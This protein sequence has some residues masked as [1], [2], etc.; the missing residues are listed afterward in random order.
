MPRFYALAHLFVT[1]S[2][3][4]V[5]PMTLI[6]A[7]TSGLPIVARF[8]PAYVGLARDGYSGYLVPSDRA[9]AARAMELLH[10]PA[11]RERFAAHACA[12]SGDLATE[13][14]V[15]QIEALYRQVMAGKRVGEG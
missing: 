12:L 15:N 8:D 7:L 13:R 5:Q 4:E 3:S 11:Q 2:L 14:H 10:N 6:E 1:A 9:L